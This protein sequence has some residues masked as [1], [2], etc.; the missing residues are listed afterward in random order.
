MSRETQAK[1]NQPPCRLGLEYQNDA[2]VASGD[3]PLPGLALH[4]AQ[5]AA[6]LAVAAVPP[7]LLHQAGVL[8]PQV[9]PPHDAV[10]AAGRKQ[11]AVL[12]ELHLDDAELLVR[13]GQAPPHGEPPPRVE[14]RDAAVHGARGQQRGDLARA[15]RRRREAQRLDAV[16][17]RLQR[18]EDLPSG[19]DVRARLALAALA[20]LRAARQPRQAD[21]PD[22]AARAPDGH[23]RALGVDGD[24]VQPALDLEPLVV[25]RQ[26]HRRLAVALHE[27]LGGRLAPDVPHVQAGVL[28]DGAQQVPVG[29]PGAGRDGGLVEP[30]RLHE[31]QRVGR[32]AAA[33]GDVDGVDPDRVVAGAEGDVDLG[34][35][36]GLGDELDLH[37]GGLGGRGVDAQRVHAELAVHAAADEEVA[38]G[39][40]E[41]EGVDGV[42]VAVDGVDAV[43]RGALLL[44]GVARVGGGQDGAR[45]GGGGGDEV[46]LAGGVV[47]VALGAAGGDQGR[48]DGVLGDGE[49]GVLVG[50]E[51]GDRVVLEVDL[52]VLVVRVHG[53]VLLVDVDLL[54]DLVGLEHLGL[55]LVAVIARGVVLGGG[56]FVLLRPLFSGGGFRLV[57]S[58]LRKVVS[59]VFG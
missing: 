25:A 41:G 15:A 46:A 1:S 21:D 2:V 32:V 35:L 29:G 50:V 33:G 16:R 57:S 10:H 34:H 24:A 45:C 59:H 28:G 53:H 38:A 17:G 19:G 22:G 51:V 13:A 30:V 54:A 55:R 8:R 37:A 43:E 48:V 23:Q 18:R 27:P 26:A 20:G 5:H 39:Q 58:A 9:P 11:P 31:L 40:G 14:D 12:D 7:P 3:D 4:E 52:L 47:G 44:R 49:D 42:G 6:A 36:L 56:H